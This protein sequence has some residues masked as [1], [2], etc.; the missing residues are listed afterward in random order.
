MVRRDVRRPEIPPLEY[1]YAPPKRGLRAGVKIE[2]CRSIDIVDRK[3]DGDRPFFLDASPTLT[4][5]SWRA[6]RSFRLRSFQGLSLG[7]KAPECTERTLNNPIAPAR[8]ASRFRPNERDP[9]GKPTQH[10]RS[11]QTCVC[12][13]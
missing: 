10:R 7:S 11:E 6:S 13:P 1:L 5:R 8:S 2:W 3:S 4:A 12:R 9:D